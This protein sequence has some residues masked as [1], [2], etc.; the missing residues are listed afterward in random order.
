MS[1]DN[2]KS[3]W[4]RSKAAVGAAAALVGLTAGVG[5]GGE[6]SEAAPPPVVSTVTMTPA[7]V[8]ATAT[9]TATA[10]LTVT[11]TATKTATAITTVSA[12][13]VTA[14]VTVTAAALPPAQVAA[15]PTPQAQPKTDAYYKNCTAA[16]SAGVA[17]LHR[18]DPGYRAGLDRDDD[19]VACE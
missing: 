8:T 18:G 4:W 5:L 9:T 13:V 14:L 10:T 17:P 15:Q 11:T 6:P 7:P 1:T 16:R 2:A 19:G 12:P 3:S